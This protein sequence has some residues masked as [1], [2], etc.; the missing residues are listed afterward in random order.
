MKR[1]LRF[2]FQIIEC[3]G[4][5]NPP[6]RFGGNIFFCPFDLFIWRTP[7]FPGECKGFYDVDPFFWHFPARAN[8]GPDPEYKFT[9]LLPRKVEKAPTK[10]D[11]T[12]VCAVNDFRAPVKWFKGDEEIVEGA[13]DKFIIEKDFI[14]H[15]KLTI[16]NAAKEDGAVYKCRIDGTKSVTKCTASFEGG[17]LNRGC[18]PPRRPFYFLIYSRRR[19]WTLNNPPCTFN[20]LILSFVHFQVDKSNLTLDM[21]LLRPLLNNVVYVCMMS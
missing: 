1:E 19:A 8:A 7:T 17:G 18:H 5:Q 16:V 2:F 6:I 3:K 14:G 20:Y 13:S 9:K 4:K 15:C 12:L 11:H 10:R 21:I